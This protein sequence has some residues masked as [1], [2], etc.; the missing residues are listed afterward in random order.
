[1]PASPVISVAILEL[2]GKTFRKVSGKNSRW[3]KLLKTGENSFDGIQIATQRFRDVIQIRV[4]I[5]RLVEKVGH[6]HRDHP[7]YRIFQVDID[8]A[9]QM[10]PQRNF[11]GG[12][13]FQIRIVDIKTAG[14][15]DL[16]VQ[17]I[18][19]GGWRCI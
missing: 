9:N 1:M 8:L 13:I 12:G 3:I 14:T 18:R 2:Q 16:P 4:Q 17:R 6:I 10:V 11:T 7:V 5:P 19:F 15:L